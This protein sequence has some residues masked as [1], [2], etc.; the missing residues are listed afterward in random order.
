MRILVAPNAFKG[1]LS[2]IE[3]AEAIREGILAVMRD[4]D[5]VTLPIADGGD[6][7]VDALVA[8]TNG[9]RR[10]VRVRGPLGEP[11]DAEYGLINDGAT[12]VIEM[13]RA[14]GLKL[15]K[16]DKRDPRITTTYGVGELLQHAYDAGARHFIVGI[17][18]SA[19]NDG[20]AG[21][22]QAL[23]Y[24]LL[25]ESGHELRPGGLALKRLARIHVGGVHANWKEAH[26]EVASDVTN[27]LTGPSG[28]SAIYGP[29]KGA[30]P[31][32]VAE[33]DAALKRL[34]GIIHRDLGVEVEHLPGAGAAGG[35][36]A[37][38][39]AFT[40]AELKPGAEMVMAALKLDARLEGA[41]L[42]ITGEGRLD[43]QTAR[44]GKG[45]AAVARHARNAGILV[46]AIGGSL[47]DET[48]LALIFDAVEATIVEPSS[49]DEVVAQAR[50][51]LVA[52]SS[53]IM[54]Q[55]VTGGRL[56][57]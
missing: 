54:R 32:M 25:D 36:G 6:G 49:L 53:R 31:E 39:V 51:L 11:V 4:A 30:T 27:P 34:A 43:S 23:G 40:G 52:A 44:F 45:P 16:P 55:L 33:L 26:V 22:A 42:V 7:T 37:G 13:A 5:V 8:A 48:E 28:A 12:A 10:V 1:S 9:E 46:V 38:L 18:G 3:A 14:A 20:G 56:R 2:A 35:L 21:M 15:L 41:N 19:T 29:Q 17:G 57:G 50:P 24:H 47:A